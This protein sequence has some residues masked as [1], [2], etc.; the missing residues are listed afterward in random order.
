MNDIYSAGASSFTGQHRCS[1]SNFNYNEDMVGK[2]VISTGEIKN[3]GKE[4]YGYKDDILM[5]D[6]AIPIVKLSDKFKDKRIF[7]VI[8]GIEPEGEINVSFGH[9]TVKNTR[10]NPKDRKLIIN[11]SGNGYIACTQ[12][13][14]SKK[15][16]KIK[17]G[18]YIHSSGIYTGIG[19]K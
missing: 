11:S 19:I 12:Y 9:I 14:S 6:E 3:L 18:D 10:A 15:I 17:N 7:G 4:V 2:I 16:R 8:S 1:F 5:M 13:I